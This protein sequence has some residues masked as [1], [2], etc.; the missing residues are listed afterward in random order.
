M[1]AIAVPIDI[2]EKE[3]EMTDRK[4]VLVTS[5]HPLPIH[6]RRDPKTNTFRIHC[7]E[8]LVVKDP[9]RKVELRAQCACKVRFTNAEAFTEPEVQLAPD[10]PREL[11]ASDSETIQF[12]GLTVDGSA[13]VLESKTGQTTGFTVDDSAV[14]LFDCKGGPVII[15][16][17]SPR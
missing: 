9:P 3:K 1:S 4:P 16:P 14:V 12:T 7:P 11:L 15:I 17:P 2:K 6:I 8:G 13:V 10:S 5:S